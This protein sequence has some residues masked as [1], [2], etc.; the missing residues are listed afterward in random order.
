MSQTSRAA[1]MQRTVL[2]LEGED[3][4]YHP[5]DGGAAV[6]V[7]ACFRSAHKALDL[8]TGSTVNSTDPLCDVLLADL[9]ELPRAGVSA[10]TARGTRY[11]VRE[12]QPD[13]EG[14]ALLA[15]QRMGR[16]D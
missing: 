2:R 13:G 10:V 6:T 15:L 5:T 3:V 11:V 4:L 9:P 1:R 7:R 12:I 14:M 16:A 8:D